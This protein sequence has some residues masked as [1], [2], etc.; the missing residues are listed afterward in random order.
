M[1]VSALM[2]RIVRHIELNGPMAVSDYMAMCL[3]DPEY[4]YYTKAEPFGANGD[5]TTAPEISQLFGEIIGAWLINAWLTVGKPSPFTLAEAGPGRGTLMKDILRTAAIE[6]AFSAAAKP[7]L[8]EASPR[9]RAIQSETLGGTAKRTQWLNDFE[10]LPDRPLFLVTN[11]FFDA[12]PI[13]Q[14]IFHRNQWVERCI[15]LGENESLQWQMGT[16]KIETDHLP[17]YLK[18]VPAEGSIVE[19]S[20][21]RESMAAKIAAH[22]AEHGGVAINFDYGHTTTAVGDTFQAVHHHAF[23]NPLQE[24]GK[25]DLTSHV[26]F[27]ALSQSA[28]S[29]GAH[30][31]QVMAQGAFLL[32][33]GLLERAGQLGAGK[34]QEVQEQIRNDVQ[35]LAGSGPQEMGELFKVWCLAQN[36]GVQIAPFEV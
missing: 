30:A 15:G 28:G 12:L 1:T 5:F 34:S 7:V 14:F 3:L 16:G 36:E 6:P 20:P 18:N 11:E 19:T 25:R 32:Q 23:A 33:C 31:F 22:I 13:R 35:R 4:G 26:D 29:Q 10:R 21:A 8:I 24:P 27:A 17:S 9:L 2:P